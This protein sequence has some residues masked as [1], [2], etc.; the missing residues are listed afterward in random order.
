MNYLYLI[1][2]ILILLLVL[3]KYILHT[4]KHNITSDYNKDVDDYYNKSIGFLKPEH[5][6]LKI[7]G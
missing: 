3:D 4:T 6:L 1:L 7:L 2:T 5:R